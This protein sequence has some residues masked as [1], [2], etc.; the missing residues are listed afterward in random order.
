MNVEEKEYNLPLIFLNS[1][2]KHSLGKGLTSTFY[3]DLSCFL[4]KKTPIFE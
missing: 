1:L 3:R 2:L 4:E